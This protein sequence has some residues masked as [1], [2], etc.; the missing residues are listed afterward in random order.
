M[1]F[2]YMFTHDLI[3]SQGYAPK[4]TGN[5]SRDD[6][7]IEVFSFSNGEL[8]KEIRLMHSVGSNPGT[9]NLILD[10]YENYIF[11]INRKGIVVQDISSSSFHGFEKSIDL[12]QENYKYILNFRT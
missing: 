6:S 10:Q 7:N 4:G 8:K 5:Y 3:I 11:S 9:P 1:T 12:Y 2:V